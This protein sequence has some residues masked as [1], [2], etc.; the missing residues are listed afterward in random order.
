MG[1]RILISSPKSGS[2]ANSIPGTPQPSNVRCATILLLRAIYLFLISSRTN[3]GLTSC[4]TMRTLSELTC[5]W[6]FT[7]FA[8]NSSSRTTAASCERARRS[9]L[10]LN[11][12]K[13]SNSPNSTWKKPT[14]CDETATSSPRFKI[15]TLSPTFYLFPFSCSTRKAIDR[16]TA[17]FGI[18]ELILKAS[19]WILFFSPFFC[20]VPFLWVSQCGRKRET[21]TTKANNDTPFFLSK[22]P[23]AF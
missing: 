1:R 22:R 11:A 9:M 2:A 16:A 19:F 23:T 21:G 6:P 13:P 7:I 4:S 14:K 10:W 18:V 8:P 3:C 20:F 5:S 12:N 17:K 15:P